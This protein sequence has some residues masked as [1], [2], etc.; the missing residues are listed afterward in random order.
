MQENKKLNKE[1]DFY[2]L[3]EE[4]AARL[5][6]SYIGE[7]SSVISVSLTGNVVARDRDF[8]NALCTEFLEANLEEKNDDE[9][10]SSLIDEFENEYHHFNSDLIYYWWDKEYERVYFHSELPEKEKEKL[11]KAGI[12]NK[13]DDWVDEDWI[14]DEWICSK[15]FWFIKRLVE[16]DKIDIEKFPQIME[17]SDYESLLMLLSISDTP[18]EDLISYLK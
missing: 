13:E 7:M 1:S 3:E 14:W 5:Q 11:R 18:I 2:S 9:E 16:N 12:Y 6:L 17:Y 8:I 4:F 10:I 15:K